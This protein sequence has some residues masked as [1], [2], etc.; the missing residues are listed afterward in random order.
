M[1]ILVVQLQVVVNDSKTEKQ[2]NRKL[3]EYVSPI[4][5]NRGNIPN[6]LRMSTGSSL[7][8]THQISIHS[9][10]QQR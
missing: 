5:V 1:R 2:R 4:G 8:C 3:V 9:Y 7:V 10:R 6:T